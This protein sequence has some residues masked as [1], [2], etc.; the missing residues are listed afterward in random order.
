MDKDPALSAA[1]DVSKTTYRIEDVRQQ[2]GSEHQL[3]CAAN[4][5]TQPVPC[6]GADVDKAGLEA[7]SKMGLDIT[8]TVEKLDKGGI[9]VTVRGL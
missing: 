5:Y 7:F 9:Y 8:Y 3:A 6:R 1:F 4:L 2:S